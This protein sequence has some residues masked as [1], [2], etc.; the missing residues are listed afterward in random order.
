MHS[1]SKN[2]EKKFIKLYKYNTDEE[3]AKILKVSYQ[4]VQKKAE[5]LGLKKEEPIKR[6]W[7]AEEVK[8]INKMY[9]ESSNELIANSLSA[10]KWQIEHIGYRL[11]LRKSKDY[12]NVADDDNDL[13]NEWSKQWNSDMKCSKGHYVTKKILEHLFPYQKIVEEEPIGNLSI[14]LLLPH[15]NIAFEFHGVQHSAYSE[16]FYKTKQDFAHAKDNDWV[17]SEML[18]SKNIS[19]VVIYHDEKLSINLIKAKLEEII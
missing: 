6:D 16:F 2:K 10:E 9:S 7:T 14:D 15:L 3:V 5:E 11:G 18:E 19:L 1:W 17:K 8:Y 4:F 13:V 12:F